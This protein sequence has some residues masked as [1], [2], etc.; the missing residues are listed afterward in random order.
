MDPIQPYTTIV[1]TNNNKQFTPVG[2]APGKSQF[3]EKNLI[4]IH[5]QHLEY[6]L[7]PNIFSS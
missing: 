2:S 5:Q 3:R 4:T 7:N 1:P 6:L